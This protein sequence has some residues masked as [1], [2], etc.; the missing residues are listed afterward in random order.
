MISNAARHEPAQF[1]RQ[2]EAAQCLQVAIAYAVIAWLLIQAGSILFRTIEANL[3]HPLTVFH[4]EIDVLKEIDVAE[5][6]A[7]HGDDVGIFA[8]A[9]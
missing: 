5:D 6:I 2:A 9:H 8:F 7:F 3:F 1:L 4:D